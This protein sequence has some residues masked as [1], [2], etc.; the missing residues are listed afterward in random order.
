MSSQTDVAEPVPEIQV[1]PIRCL[2]PDRDGTFAKLV[3]HFF[4]YS[5]DRWRGR[6]DVPT[7]SVTHIVA[8]RLVEKVL[9]DSAGHTFERLETFPGSWTKRI[10]GT[11]R[12]VLI[13]AGHRPDSVWL[14]SA[15]RVATLSTDPTGARQALRAV[16]ELYLRL[17]EGAGDVFLHGAAVGTTQRAA[18]IVGPKAAGKTTL[19]LAACGA[20][21]SYIS[22]DRVRIY[23]T[24]GDPWVATFPMALRVHPGTL[25]RYPDW[26]QLLLT[27][28]TLTRPQEPRRLGARSPVQLA[29]NCPPACKFELTTA[30]VSTH[31]G[32]ATMAE[33]PLRVV[34]IPTMTVGKELAAVRRLSP[35]EAA[36]LLVGQC[37][38]LHEDTWLTPWIPASREGFDAGRVVVALRRLLNSVPV[39]SL[40]F[41]TTRDSVDKAVALVLR[42]AVGVAG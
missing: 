25:L 23:G 27:S 26:A 18:I 15:R 41:G 24:D 38:S 4:P 10:A 39:Y 2:S 12:T 14:T 36:D 32:L 11:L 9:G 29:A 37:T 1:G 33:A 8:P 3:Q 7:W 17:Y 30:E 20:G 19:A 6:A 21:L 31:L 5:V 34:L 40:C 42:A 13:P 16:R 35:G 22:N 28:S